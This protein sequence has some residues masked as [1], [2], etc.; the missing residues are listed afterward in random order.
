[1]LPEWLV[2]WALPP[3]Q[4]YLRRRSPMPPMGTEL[5]R[6]SAP[7]VPLTEEPLDAAELA[8]WQ[9]DHPMPEP[10]E[11]DLERERRDA[12]A[13]RARWSPRAREC[14]EQVVRTGRG[15][16]DDVPGVALEARLARFW[17]GSSVVEVEAWSLDGSAGSSCAAV[18]ARGSGPD[19]VD[20][21]A[22]QVAVALAQVAT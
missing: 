19:V 14:A 18:V 17:W 16:V 12:D 13:A 15:S 5:P 7:Y 21:V 1:M 10:D 4:R 3:A 6:G 22:L 11:A 8:R 20:E 2:W 9:A